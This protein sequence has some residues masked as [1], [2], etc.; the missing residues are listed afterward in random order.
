MKRKASEAINEEVQAAYV[1]KKRLDHLKEQAEALQDPVAA[2]VTYIFL[3]L[4]SAYCWRSTIDVKN[5]NI[6]AEK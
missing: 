3:I 2:Q 1:C 6:S 5:R 4:Y